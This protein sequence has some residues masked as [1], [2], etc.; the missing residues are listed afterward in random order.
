MRRTPAG[1]VDRHPH[2]PGDDERPD[3]PQ[4]VAHA[5]GLQRKAA[6]AA[7]EQSAGI[8]LINGAISAMD[9][10]TQQNAALVQEA[11]TRARNL[12]DEA[13][14]LVQQVSHYRVAHVDG[15]APADDGAAA[16]ARFRPAVA[17]WAA[18]R[19]GCRRRRNA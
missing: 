14:A 16:G 19:V 8:G 9:G 3:C 2:R 6:L 5:R 17:A 15:A 7:A 18:R 4:P 12:E 10:T 11:M 13:N 1:R